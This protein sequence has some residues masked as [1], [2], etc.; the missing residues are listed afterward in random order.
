M[1]F[2]EQLDAVQAVDPGLG[3][4]QGFVIDVGGVEQRAVEKAFLAEQDGEGI[5]LLAGAATG[6]PDLERRIGAQMRHDFFADGAEI[7]RVA[8]QFA[9][10]NREIGQKLAQHRRIVQDHV[11][12]HRKRATLEMVARLQQPPLDRGHGVAAEIVVIALEDGFQQQAHLD[13][14]RAFVC[15]GRQFCGGVHRGIQTRTSEISF[16]TSKGLAI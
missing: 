2:A 5:Q 8:K 14:V 1:V 9:D 13:I 11:L 7:K 6:D 3:A 15:R 10:L 16:S 12:Q 4:F